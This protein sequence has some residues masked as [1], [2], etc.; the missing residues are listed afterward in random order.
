MIEVLKGRF[1]VT[2]EFEDDS[3]EHT[4]AEILSD[5]R[6]TC[7]LKSQN[8]VAKFK[9]LLVTAEGL[10]QYRCV[11][12]KSEEKNIVVGQLSLIEN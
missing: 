10:Q 12:E 8:E 11:V 2:L 4:E 3:F 1:P 9:M 5:N 7:L 6:F